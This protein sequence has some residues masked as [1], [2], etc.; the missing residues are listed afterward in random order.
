MLP[1][2]AVEMRYNLPKGVTQISHDV[3]ALHM[4][5]FFICCLIGCLVFGV[6]FYSMYKH[7][8]SRGAIPSQFHE[9]VKAEV[10]WTIIP[11]IILALMAIPAT[12]TLVAMENTHESELTILVTGSQW[13]WHYEYFEQDVAY[14]SLLSTPQE[15]IHNQQ[16]KGEYYLLEVDK[17]LILPT[18]RKV[19]FLFTSDDVIHSWW[20]PE[21]SI[22]KDVLPGFI[23]ES[24]VNIERAGVYRGQ[25]TELCGKDH[26]FMPIVVKAID[27][28][29]FDNWLAEQK[30]MAYEAKEDAALESR[31]ELS[32]TELMQLGEAVYVQ[33]CAACHQVN[34][35]GL[36]GIFPALKDSDIVKNDIAAHIDIVVNGVAGTAMQSFKGQLSNKEMAAVI[37]YERNAWGNATQDIIQP[38][39]IA[40]A[41]AE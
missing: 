20:M 17:P 36:Q 37:T 23:N 34:G 19:R 16:D 35:L 1:L 22:K 3:Y 26:A 6:M 28:G 2:Q 39:D 18:H 33:R 27:G 30:E 32:M 10:T 12:K 9:N 14:F 38:A 4:T 41:K 24:W 25:C 31:Q 11:F 15:A 5:I 8:K 13:K 7:R 40:S 21:F 29:E